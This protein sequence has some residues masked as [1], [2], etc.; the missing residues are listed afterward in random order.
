[1]SE[2]DH[3]LLVHISTSLARLESKVDALVQR[4]DGI[5]RRLEDHETRLRAV[6]GD[7]V[8]VRESTTAKRW[9][10]GTVIAAIVTIGAT[11]AN[12]LFN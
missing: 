10:V 5:D 7:Y 6:E 8:S 1:M 11:W 4:I 3:T 12:I 9:L 2:T